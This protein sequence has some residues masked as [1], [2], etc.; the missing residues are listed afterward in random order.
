MLSWPGPDELPYAFVHERSHFPGP[1][2]ELDFDLNIKAME[3]GFNEA[4]IQYGLALRVADQ[5]INCFVYEALFTSPS[6]P[7]ERSGAL[8]P[9]SSVL[10]VAVDSLEQRWEGEW[11]PGVR[12]HL[13]A[14]DR[15]E[16]GALPLADLVAHLR[17]MRERAR[18]LWHL[19]FA[20]FFPML[21][22]ISQFRTLCGEIFGGFSPDDVA[23]LLTGLPSKT[24]EGDD[25]LW[26]IGRLF[27]ASPAAL[28][29]LSNEGW[30]AIRAALQAV[31]GGQALGE[32][33]ERY[34][35]HFGQRSNNWSIDQPF[36]IEDPTPT[37]DFL[38]EYT[39]MSA[40]VRHHHRLRQRREELEAEAARELLLL[41]HPLTSA[42]YRLLR[43]A[44]IAT[45]LS[46]ESNYWIEGLGSFRIRAICLEAGRRMVRAGAITEVEDVFYLDFADLLAALEGRP[47][48]EVAA[49]VA[50]NRARYLEATAIVPPV[51]LGPSP[52][53]GAPPMEL[54]RV[55]DLFF[56]GP[57]PPLT[58]GWTLAGFGASPGLARGPVR[59]ISSLE[60]AHRVRHGD[61]L[62][63]PTTSPAWT[64]LFGS[65]AA[66]VTD[67]GGLLCHGA[68]VAREYALPAVVGVGRA[69]EVLQEGQWVEVDGRAGLI[70]II[71]PEDLSAPILGPSDEPEEGGGDQLLLSEARLLPRRWVAVL[72]QRS[73]AVAAEMIEVADAMRREPWR[74]LP[75]PM[76]TQKPSVIPPSTEQDI[77]DD[78]F[79]VQRTSGNTLHA[80]TRAAAAC[81][82]GIETGPAIGRPE[83][84][85]EV[86][87][88]MAEMLHYFAT[89]QEPESQ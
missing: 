79:R 3:W 16:L 12:G 68:V 35:A 87:A 29:A 60:E 6:L 13:A 84:R 88:A 7:D 18:D 76:E 17:D 38:R 27:R 49:D 81:L 28:E 45:W 71:E 25:E 41:P 24:T 70:R 40:G 44:R 55:L 50:R 5:R 31:E 15:V 11:L 51:E 78:Y 57:T 72:A 30:P 67:S 20:I 34:L 46:E 85:Q 80:L 10:A 83:Q 77:Y 4:L 89:L 33:F 9:A 69:T 32:R 56:G 75:F 86:R 37:L 74:L 58:E 66:L 43:S 73:P 36:W 22:A 52:E 53:G 21:S 54:S 64:P 42:F 82:H 48:A 14:W 39:R 2:R 23:V 62:V 65:V 61:V 47:A 8:L 19:H 1:T 63:T 59:I 26:E